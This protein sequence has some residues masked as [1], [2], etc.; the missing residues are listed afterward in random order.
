MK[1]LLALFV[2]VVIMSC[3]SN[4]LPQEAKE[5][6]TLYLI[7]HAKSSHSDT[8]LADFDRPLS[9]KGKAAAELMGNKM[10][11][12]G[13]FFDAMIVSPSKRT[14]ST[15]K[16]VGRVVEF[17]KD[18]IQHDS[19]LYRCR[20]QAL[21][22]AVHGIDKNLKRVAIV[23]HNPSTIQAANHFQKDTIFTEVP[24]GGIIAIEFKSNSWAELGN[25]TGKYRF[26]EYPKLYKKKK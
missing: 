16:R 17:V 6:R 1:C 24:T 2:L 10:L 12:R 19:T 9:K 4:T 14:K 22:A 11:E 8:S 21:I 25:K 20:T 13:V 7:R 23:G 26:F 3:G 5:T 18:S 15:A